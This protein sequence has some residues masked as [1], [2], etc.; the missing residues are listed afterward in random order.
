MGYLN[1]TNLNQK[2]ITCYFCFDTFEID[3]GIDNSF[4][5]KNTEIFDC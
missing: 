2:L 3:L 1:N 4:S 5:G